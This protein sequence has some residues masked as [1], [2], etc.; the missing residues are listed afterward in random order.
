MRTPEAN[1]AVFAFLLHYPWEFLQ[2][3]FF[4]GMA[5][6]PHWEATMFCTRAT[7]GDVGIALT[8]F[9][10]GAGAARSR[11]WLARPLRGA[12]AAVFVGT[13]LALTVVFERLALGPLNRWSYSELMPVVPVLN[14]GLVPLVQ[15]VV[16][17]ILLIWVVRRQLAGAASLR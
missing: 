8:A 3:P 16:L 4:A 1:V 12:P 2:V 6:A 13:G 7:L 9:W 17:P 11:G 10:A 15:W 5:S 14:V